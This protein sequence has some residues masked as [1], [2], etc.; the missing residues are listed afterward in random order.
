MK[1]QIKVW[2]IRILSIALIVFAIQHWGT[3]LYKQYFAPKKADVYIP[4]AKV[5]VGKFTISFHEI[6]NLDAEK[7]VSVNSESSGKIISIIA[8][9]K[10]VAA[11]DVIAE[12]DTTDLEREVRNQKLAY[13]NALADVDRAEAEFELLKKSNKTDFEQADAQLKFDENE[14]QLAKDDLA[15]KERLAAEKLIP[16]SQVDQ[17]KGVVRSKQLAVDKGKAQ[18]ELKTKEIESKENQKKADIKNVEFKAEM[19]KISLDE[20]ERRT[21]KATIKAPAAG[22]VVITN[23]WT[24]DGRRK[25]QEGDTVRPR[26]SICQL[27]DLSNMTVKVSVGESD[28]PKVHVDMPVLLRLEAIP[29]KI[30]HGT[31]K[32]ISSLATEKSPWEGGTPGKKD[33]EV[34]IAVKEN[35]PK[36]IKPGMTADVEFICD[37]IKNAVYIPIEAVVERN[38]KTYVFLDN[39][40]Q[41][42]VT[43]GK[44]NDNFICI[45]K[46]LQEGQV[47]ALRDPTRPLDA[48]EAG[49]SAPGAEKEKKPVPIPGTD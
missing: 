25:L 38:G 34:S 1:Q 29:D 49:S 13:E 43:T 3:P 8:D 32:D 5:K 10:M 46:G 11:G 2:G 15:K 44:Y 14:H 40:K 27:P 39:G 41:V 21:E 42:P 12:L 4:T 20:A 31:V 36:T 26:Q 35:D 33:F 47:I 6:G 24:G 37:I 9:G 48:Q 16:G 22:L 23:D 18:L 30:F 45:E 28:A 17:A 19:A 7:S